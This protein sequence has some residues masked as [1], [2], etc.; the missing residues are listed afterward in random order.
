MKQKQQ[1]IRKRE[2]AGYV[3]LLPYILGIVLFFIVPV[4][5]SLMISFGGVNTHN[6][7]DIFVSGIENYYT[8]FRGDADFL[9]M[10]LDSVT[11]MGYSVPIILVV[12]FIVAYLLKS[13]FPGRT[14]YRCIFF[15]PVVIA[16]GILGTFQLDN[17][18]N[19]IIYAGETNVVSG[20][21]LTASQQFVT[22]LLM[23]NN[24]S[25]EVSQYIV[26]WITNILDVLNRSGIQILLFL[27][28]LQS[29]PPALYE[30]S[31]VE[32]ATGWETFWKITLPMIS[33]YVLVVLV[34]TII[35]NFV[36]TN[37]TIL[38]Y[39]YKWAF[40]KFE[41]GYSAA[42]AWI[43]FV[44]IGAIVLLAFLIT[45]PLIFYQEDKA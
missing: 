16:S 18:L 6:G 8:A 33:P 32:G 5:Q 27:S 15:L 13:E 19:T 41:F 12:S 11:S 39:I 40:E 34:Y 28:A 44:I 30:A 20:E 25:P 43:Y 38:K 42:M 29:I 45:R 22:E 3:F 17:I 23:S 9:P 2:R 1:L 10:L 24:L 37:N 7:Y 14:V 35:E 4:V 31:K 26:F 36:N 21:V